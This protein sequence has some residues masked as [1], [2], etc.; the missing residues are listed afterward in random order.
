MRTTSIVLAT[1]L[2]AIAAQA[3]VPEGR[4]DARAAIVTPGFTN[5]QAPGSYANSAGEPSIG[6]NW[7][8]GNVL[9][10]AYT[11]TYR[12]SFASATPTWT[13]V[14]S[15]YTSVINIDPIL[16]TDSVAGRTYAGGLA[17]ECSVLAYTDADGAP[18][19]PMTNSCAAPA[20][21]HET[22][23]GGA[24]HE[25]RP[26]QATFPRAVYYCAQEVVQQCAVSYNGG[27][28]FSAGVPMSSTCTGLLGHVKVAPDGTVYV[29]SQR[30]GGRQGLLVSED[31]GLTW[32]ARLIPGSGV[33][34]AG[35][36]PS[37][38]ISENGVV[39]AAW[40]H[41]D[42]A[43]M[44][45]VSHDKG[46]TWSEPRNVGAPKALRAT[47]FSSV[48]AGD[49][50]RAA[51]AFLGT[52]SSN[53][54]PFAAGFRGEWHLY[55]AFTYDAGATWTTVQVTTDPVQRGFICAGGITCTGGRNLL[56]FIDA[57]V[58]AQGRVL[59][60]YADGCIT[61]CITST[62]LVQSGSAKGTI[63]RQTSGSTLRAVLDP[64]GASP[65]SAPDLD[66]QGAAGQ[67]KLTW[68]TPA[69]FGAPITEYQVWR[70]TS[71]GASARFTT[72]P[73]GTNSYVDTSV[74]NGVTYYYEL[75]ALSS[76]GESG[77]S[78]Q[79]AETPRL[80]SPPSEP[81]NLTA[82]QPVMVTSDGLEVSWQNP[83]NAGSWP[84]TEYRIYRGTTP[85]AKTLLTTTAPSYTSFWDISA[86]E[87][88]TYYYEVTAT[89]DSGESPPSNEASAT[90]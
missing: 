87:G 58:D 76:A 67:V 21:D 10:Q 36:D 55:V 64:P 74:A 79:V 62:T 24:W 37:V 4:M 9:F 41:W 11:Q 35:F 81:R 31:N 12:V 30:C 7:K 46:L 39:Y 22:V 69:T 26:P 3:V 17:G 16:F 15:I 78:I 49:D 71:P 47:T 14:H 52:T 68:N 19:T 48:V 13:P 38:G 80:G 44:V 88:V 43:Q 73:A 66:S 18:W 65:P 86:L 27:L 50:D 32:D 51:V 45:S 1:L 42:N 53:G 8:T 70:A 61:T 25:P 63:A 29:P 83:A 72:V 2:L 90:A 60:A 57:T 56:D 77:K 34:G 33:P 20:W 5:H 84:V 23:G 82:R 40:Q 59:V 6:V 85:T 75:T 89:N 54:N 28:S